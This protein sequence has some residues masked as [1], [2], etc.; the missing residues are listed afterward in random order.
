MKI[1]NS[2]QP[3]NVHRERNERIWFMD[4]RSFLI[5]HQQQYT[6]LYTNPFKL[7]ESNSIE[8]KNA[9]EFYMATLRLLVRFT[10]HDHSSPIFYI[11][12]EIRRRTD[13]TYYYCSPFVFPGTASCPCDSS[14]IIVII[15]IVCKEFDF[16]FFFSLSHPFTVVI[17]RKTRYS[18]NGYDNLFYFTNRDP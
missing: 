15:V 18:W 14:N 8:W 10:M 9:I 12:S 13:N 6:G 4:N 3:T 5:G 1:T 2:P 16:S 17:L 7:C 11:I